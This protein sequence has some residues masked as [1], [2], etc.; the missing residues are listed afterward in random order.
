MSFVVSPVMI[1]CESLS[2]VQEA[3]VTNVIYFVVSPVI[4]HSCILVS[5]RTRE[6]ML[7]LPCFFP[8]LPSCVSLSCVQEAQ[9]TNDIYLPW[10]YPFHPLVYPC[11]H[12]AQRTNVIYW[13]GCF[14]PS[15]SPCVPLPPTRGTS[16]KCDSLFRWF[17]IHPV[18]P[19]P[20]GVSPCRIR[21]H[22]GTRAYPHRGG[23][24]R[25]TPRGEAEE[26]P[27]SVHAGRKSYRGAPDE[28]VQIV[29]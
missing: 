20:F 12:E 16:N 22:I 2:C 1:P 10:V 27:R 9:A 29:S 28:G 3:H 7:Y 25:G 26:V 18:I 23:S 19:H 4:I 24:S 13:C 6:P 5:M 15:S 21:V 11:L 8:S 17:G 14:H